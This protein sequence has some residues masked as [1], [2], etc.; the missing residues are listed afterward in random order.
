VAMAAGVAACDGNVSINGEKGKPLAE[1]DL[2]GTPPEE[3][4]LLGPD[5]IRVTQG[6]KLAITV[7]GDKAVTD[8][9]RFTLKDGTLGVLRE[10]KSMGDGKAVVNV[11][12]P[13]PK[14][15]TMAGSGKINS[16]ALARDAKVT[17]AGSGDIETPNVASDKLDLTIAGSGSYRSAGNVKVLEVS[18]VGS[19]SAA[20]DA[21]KTD[22]ADLTIAGSG[23]STFASDGEVK[24]KIMGSGSVTVRGRARCTVES[25]GSGK[26]VCEP[27]NG[28]APTSEKP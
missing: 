11:T 27:G 17:I 16:A 24:A 25:M 10:G 2:T 15:L 7:E 9:L 23:N 28:T 22:K 3:L 21:L 5:E 19:G 1:I 26:L 8:K 14:T 18:I 20:M 6:D 12:M 4:V 13:A